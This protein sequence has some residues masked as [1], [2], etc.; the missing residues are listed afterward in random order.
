MRP[1]HR[2]RSLVARAGVLA[3]ALAL[4]GCAGGGPLLHPAQTLPKGEMRIAGGLSANAVA[5]GSA[6]ALTAARNEAA[7]D[8][9]GTTLNDPSFVKGALV[10]A[11]I[12]PGVAPFV[13]ARVGMWDHFEGGLAYTG[14]GVRADVRRSFALSQ[15]GA[16]ALSLGVG[17]SG[18]LYGNV[19][20]TTLPG[21]DL[22]DLRGWGA[23]VPILVGYQSE[24]GLYMMWLGVRG[25]WEHDQIA[26]VTSE[27]KAVSLG[28]PPVGLS[29]EKYWGGGVLGVATGFRHLHVALE[30]D[31]NATYVTG[32]FGGTQ[33]SIVGAAI[34]PATALWWDF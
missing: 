20:G 29:G 5:G 13:A 18:A 21:V 25:G 17:G 28:Y 27:P 26:N 33:A 22:S 34:S 16:W 30:I 2:L 9:N 32:S 31:A 8:V 10:A 3:S 19:Q 11:A 4:G 15:D 6:S 1:H 12:G 24:G 7:A 23:D 14:R